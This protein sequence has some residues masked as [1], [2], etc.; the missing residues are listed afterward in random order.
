MDVAEYL[1]V[2]FSEVAHI[3]SL[4]FL[5]NVFFVLWT[6]F[7]LYASH[8][9]LKVLFL[10]LPWGSSIIL[11]RYSHWERI[12]RSSTGAAYS[13]RAIQTILHKGEAV[14]TQLPQWEGAI[15]MAWLACYETEISHYP[16][17]HNSLAK[18]WTVF[19]FFFCTDTVFAHRRLVSLKYQ[20]II[21]PPTLSTE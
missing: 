21:Y 1:L 5:L 20:S 9:C 10:M 3:F 16:E 19:F 4:L 2:T 12:F 15:L 17:Y 18:Q 11:C 6:T 7:S 14:V 8:V 13:L